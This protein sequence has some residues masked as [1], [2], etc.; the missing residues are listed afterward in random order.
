MRRW[1]APDLEAPSRDRRGIVRW[2]LF[3]FAPAEPKPET[4]FSNDFFF[5]EVID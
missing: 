5:T 3:C 2:E 4:K 1:K